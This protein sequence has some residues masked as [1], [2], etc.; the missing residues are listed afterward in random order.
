MHFEDCIHLNNINKHQIKR[1]FC[2]ISK[3]CSNR[4]GKWKL[5]KDIS[6]PDYLLTEAKKM[7]GN[8]SS[9][10]VVAKKADIKVNATTINKT[11]QTV[12]IYQKKTVLRKRFSLLTPKYKKARIT[13][14]L[15]KLKALVGGQDETDKEIGLVINYILR[16]STVIKDFALRNLEMDKGK[17]TADDAIDLCLET[18]ISQYMLRQMRSFLN[19]FPNTFNPFPSEKKILMGQKRRYEDFEKCDLRTGI[20]QCNKFDSN[21][22]CNSMAWG[23]FENVELFIS[24]I[25]NSSFQQHKTLTFEGVFE[26]KCWLRVEIDKGGD[27]TKLILHPVN[28]THGA[29][30]V[31]DGHL[32][33]YYQDTDDRDNISKYFKNQLDILGNME[34]SLINIGGQCR[35]LKIFYI[36]DMK[37]QSLMMGHQGQ[38]AT[39]PCLYCMVEKSDL[40]N[41][42]ALHHPNETRFPSRSLN[43]YL[44]DVIMNH[45]EIVDEPGNLE[46][47][48]RKVGK[49]HG[50]ITGHPIINLKEI[51]QLVPPFMHI[52]LGVFNKF[53]KVLVDYLQKQDN[54]SQLFEEDNSTSYEEKNI[55]YETNKKM[56]GKNLTGYVTISNS[57]SRLEACHKGDFNQNLILAKA[58][59]NCSKMGHEDFVECSAP[60]CITQDIEDN[61]DWIVCINCEDWWCMQCA[62]LSEDD[63]KS[64]WYCEK[65]LQG[66]ISV[67]L[68][69]D[70]FADR[71][72]I[73]LAQLMENNNNVSTSSIALRMSKNLL[74]DKRSPSVRALFQTINK[75]YGVHQQTYHSNA[76]VGN[77]CMKMLKNPYYLVQNI[78]DESKQHNFYYL[79]I[80]LNQIFQIMLASKQLSEEEIISLEDEILDFAKCMKDLFPEVTLTPKMH[81]LM[82]HV[83]DFAQKYKTCGLLSEQSLEHSHAVINRQDRILKNVQQKQKRIK[84]L[85][86]RNLLLTTKKRIVSK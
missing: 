36:G 77:H 39:Y 47:N 64:D 11:V 20:S 26:D 10:E 18:N 48:A 81:V 57:E 29:H 72:K 73:K 43:D 58:Q 71:K 52:M 59:G 76:F 8:I 60:L 12:K 16:S 37:A 44:E 40:S 51:S 4:S 23:C 46:L 35:E 33:G 75:E 70:T 67:P 68:L 55:T 19:S 83:V 69:L 5:I 6:F 13:M 82:H 31:S 45:N 53:F 25:F 86:K 14:I 1:L 80:T 17:M 28:Y 7:K 65:C 62:A 9:T 32:L 84:L 50:S 3:E 15:K 42:T 34:G 22:H 21:G 30:I 85:M 74:K 56:Y 79:F 41:V 2:N 49:N 66:E 78:L 24:N 61:V 38:A 63:S 54:C 27:S